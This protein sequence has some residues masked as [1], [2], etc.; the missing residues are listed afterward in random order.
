MSAMRTGLSLQPPTFVA[1]VRPVPSQ[2]ALPACLVRFRSS[3]LPGKCAI[4]LLF[5]SVSAAGA[6]LGL[7]VLGATV[8]ARPFVLA[9]QVW[10]CVQKSSS[11]RRFTCVGL[12]AG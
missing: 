1:L 3:F 5:R 4:C 12:F 8:E 2:I 7:A 10:S 9:G 11:L 6:H